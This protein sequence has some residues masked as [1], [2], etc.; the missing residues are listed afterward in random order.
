[1]I[2]VLADPQTVQWR[3][4]A[5]PATGDIWLVI[6]ERAFPSLRWNDFVIVIVAA[7]LRALSRLIRHT[8]TSETLRFMEGPWAVDVAI[9]N[10]SGLLQIAA[11]RRYTEGAEVVATDTV[12]AVD[13][14]H[15]LIAVA[16]KLLMT[17]KT[18][19]WE[20]GDVSALSATV[21]D[22]TS[23]LHE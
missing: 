14:C 3:G 12:D 22:A 2:A 5:R 10:S 4:A 19:S 1:M 11:I 18:H 17:C 7:W 20:S 21:V 23:L 15:Q 13:F 8:S 6:D 16:N 9:A